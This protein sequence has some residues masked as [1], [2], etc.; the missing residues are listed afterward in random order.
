MAAA[1]GNFSTV[2]EGPQEIRTCEVESLDNGSCLHTLEEMQ[3]ASSAHA[4][5]IEASALALDDMKKRLASLEE[6]INDQLDERMLNTLRHA[7]VPMADHVTAKLVSFENTLN[8]N[9][10]LGHCSDDS[11]T[12]PT[13]PE[14]DGSVHSK[15]WNSAFQLCVLVLLLS[16]FVFSTW[17]TVSATLALVSAVHLLYSIRC[18]FRLRVCASRILHTFIDT[19]VKLARGYAD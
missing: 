2:T 18:R 11:A 15:L 12:G 14:D 17:P 5:A 13:I 1:P 10:I 9:T 6:K 16:L 19:P 4:A 7:I 8:S 3:D